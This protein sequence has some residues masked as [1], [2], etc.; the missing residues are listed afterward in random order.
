VTPL[1]G[2][3][4]R[5]YS[6]SRR[7]PHQGRT[8]E[9]HR[10]AESIT[11]DRSHHSTSFPQPLSANTNDASWPSPAHLPKVYSPEFEEVAF[12]E[13]RHDGVLGSSLAGSRLLLR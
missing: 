5:P 6:H 9:K 8:G 11:G 3:T 1:P 4:T 2:A 7:N 12:S 10:P 13:L